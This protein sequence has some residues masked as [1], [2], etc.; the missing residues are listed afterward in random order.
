MEFA[1]KIERVILPPA[2]RDKPASAHAAP[3]CRSPANLE[4]TR[5]FSMRLGL[6][7]G[8]VP[9]GVSFMVNP[10]AM[11]VEGPKGGSSNSRPSLRMIRSAKRH[12]LSRSH[13][14]GLMS[15]HNGDL[16]QDHASM[17]VMPLVVVLGSLP[18]VRGNQVWTTERLRVD[19]YEFA[20]R[21][22]HG[23]SLRIRFLRPRSSLYHLA[24]DPRA[25]RWLHFVRD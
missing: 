8:E 22:R 3:S 5:R 20:R 9:P 12:P 4:S 1:Q 25:E 14:D 10:H 11:G 7:G 2:P 13:L 15:S 17:T 6:G 19:P 23:N 21:G 24:A 18:Y 16:A